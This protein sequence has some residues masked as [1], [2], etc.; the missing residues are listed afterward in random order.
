[1]ITQRT[2]DKKCMDVLGSIYRGCSEPKQLR[3]GAKLSRESLDE[4]L[5]VLGEKDLVIEV[6]MGDGEVV[7]YFLT[8]KGL[9]AVDMFAKV[10]KFIKQYN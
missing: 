4:V 9:M 10:N 3:F 5:D 1:M 6:D 2:I 8:E 7:E